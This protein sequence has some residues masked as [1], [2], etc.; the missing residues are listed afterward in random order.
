MKDDDKKEEQVNEDAWWVI[1]EFAQH[2][3]QMFENFIVPFELK[4]WDR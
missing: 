2:H 4:V 1:R 3:W